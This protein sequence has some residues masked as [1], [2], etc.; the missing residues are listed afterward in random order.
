MIE[1]YIDNLADLRQFLKAAREVAGYSVNQV[2]TK[3]GID[4]HL[5]RRVEDNPDYTVN[6]KY[7]FILLEFYGL[8][9]HIEPK[10]APDPA[11][12]DAE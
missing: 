2:C 1:G 11:T 8:Q 12:G 10:V 7:I 5:L 9:L 4:Y 3:T 6:M